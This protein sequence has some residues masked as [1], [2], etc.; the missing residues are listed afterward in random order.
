VIAVSSS[1]TVFGG[2]TYDGRTNVDPT[3][4]RDI[5]RIMR[6]YATAAFHESPRRILMI[7]LGSGSW[8]Q[9]LANHPDV[10]RIVTIEINPGYVEIMRHYGEIS[11]VIDN[12][13]S[14]IVFD[15]GRRYLQHSDEKF[16][17]IVQ[18]T[19]VF[20]RGHSTNVLSREYLE[21]SKQH[22]APGGIIYY[23]STTSA[24]SQRT[25]AE[26]F[27]YAMRFQNMIIGSETPIE[28]NYERW[29]DKMLEWTIDGVPVVAPENALLLPG[30]IRKSRW[31]GIPAWETRDQILARTAKNLVITDDNMASE[32]RDKTHYP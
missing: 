7:G 16:D 6:A 22:L 13:K 11:S 8:L 4:G 10:G 17:L 25:G 32:W 15:D 28:I 29:R 20:W 12:P 1:G 3:P 21:L 18:N 14:K 26:V 23:N 24:A 5:N 19:I 27:P 31:R 30:L 9:V 2:G